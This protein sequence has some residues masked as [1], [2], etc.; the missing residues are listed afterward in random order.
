MP[1]TPKDKVTF[2]VTYILYDTMDY[3]DLCDQIVT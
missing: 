2:N 3:P 1:L